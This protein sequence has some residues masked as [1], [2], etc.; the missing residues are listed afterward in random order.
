MV[1]FKKDEFKLLWPVYIGIFITM[2]SD[3]TN[4]I[5]VIYFVQKGFS[6][7]Q[8]SIL[9]GILALGIVLFEIP[10]GALADTLGR[11]KSVIIGW[12]CSGVVWF[13]IPL[14]NDF[15]LMCLVILLNTFLFTMI[16]GADEAWVVDLLKKKKL[17]KLQQNYYVNASSI[18]S[19]GMFL[20]GILGTFVIAAYGMDMTFYVAGVGLLIGGF[21]H[22]FLEADKLIAHKMSI[23]KA[24]KDT[25]L[26]SKQAIVYVRNNKILLNLT[27]GSFFIGLSA[28][29]YVAWQP[30]FLEQGIAI[31]YF[32]LLGSL[33]ALISIGVPHFV[34]II[35]N[36]VKK[37]NILLANLTLLAAVTAILIIFIPGPIYAIFVFILGHNI[38]D[39]LFIP[40]ES[41]Y[42]QRNSSSKLRAT[43]GS[44]KSM[45]IAIPG[46]FGFL[47]GGGLADFLGPG[48]TLS[49]AGVIALPAVYFYLKARK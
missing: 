14:I 45:A 19:L 26:A 36:K 30:Y 6:I 21:M 48:A 16:S 7:F 10:T 17:G 33:G 20:A 47:L 28:A 3:A 13:L 9:L 49:I 2:L 22:I 41:D 37:E 38:I 32:T 18:S 40:I 24:L 15:Y 43:I 11:K 27:F 12:M 5:F 23:K 39:R 34:E 31:E 35:K 4:F 46:F 42:F 1:L 25:W 8:T 29:G 44:T